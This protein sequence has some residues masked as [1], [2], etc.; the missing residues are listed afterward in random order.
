MLERSY[1]RRAAAIVDERRDSVL[2]VF[3][4]DECLDESGFLRCP[5][6]N[7]VDRVPELGAVGNQLVN[8]N[9]ASA[10][11]SHDPMKVLG[12]GVAAS[13]QGHFL[14][15]EIRIRERNRVLDDADQHVSATVR[16]EFEAF[17]HGR[18]AACRVEY[19]IEPGTAG[20]CA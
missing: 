5:N 9:I 15:V 10:D 7:R 2:S 11:G 18:L 8:G 13:E 16:H 1:G 12:G 17:F 19:D 6:R 3:N 4:F 20:E 14:A